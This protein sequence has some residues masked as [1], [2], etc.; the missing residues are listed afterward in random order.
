MFWLVLETKNIRI[1]VLIYY[2][3]YALHIEL[4]KLYKTFF[5][6]HNFST[7]L[8]FLFAL[9]QTVKKICQNSKNNEK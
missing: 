7:F 8:K 5:H 1:D 3:K 2:I 6:P 4:Y 9:E